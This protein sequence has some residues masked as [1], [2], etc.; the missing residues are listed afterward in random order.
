VTTTASVIVL[1]DDAGKGSPIGILVVLVLCVAVY[2]LYRSMSRHL[3]KVP[4]TFDPPEDHP[5]E[6]AGPSA[7]NAEPPAG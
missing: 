5:A 7:E 6:Q 1:A 2:F 4:P 3:R